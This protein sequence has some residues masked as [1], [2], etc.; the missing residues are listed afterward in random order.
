MFRHT[1]PIGRIFGIV[2]DLD[3]SWFLIL[4]LLAWM[5]AVSYYPTEF[6]GWS[7]TQYWLMGGIT[8]V[9]LFVSVLLHEFG[10]SLVAI[11][12]GIRVPRITLFLFG[13]V[14]Q[15]AAEP[16]SAAAEF[17][18][19]IAGPAVSFLLAILC[20]ELRP[21]VAGNAPAL[22]LAKYLALLNFVLGLFNLIP[23]FPLDGGRVFQAIVWGLTRSYQ[24]ATVVAAATGRFFGFAFIFFG[25]WQAVGGDFFNGLWIAFV[26]WFIESAAGSQLQQQLLKG[27]LSG[28]KVSEVM[29]REFDPISSSSTVQDLVEDHVLTHGRRFFVVQGGNGATGLLTLA[30]IQ[31]VPRSAWPTAHVADVMVP[32]DKLISIPADAEVWAALEKMGRDGVHQLPVISDGKIAGVL[33]REGLM[34]F[35]RVL[36]MIGS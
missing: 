1:I 36:R 8:A 27:I 25:V 12:Y 35:L 23:G 17:W 31:R 10:H 28:H 32:P 34:N 24:R 6:R 19:A 13:G 16:E 33:T 5:L 3:Y 21:L 7:T 4:G 30:D 22:A 18:I 11:S 2:V 15:I 29:D 14:S 9:L 26:G 20:W